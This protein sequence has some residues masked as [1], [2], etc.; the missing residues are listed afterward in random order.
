MRV[1]SALLAV[2]ITAGYQGAIGLDGGPYAQLAVRED[3]AIKK[4]GQGN[5]PTRLVIFFYK[6]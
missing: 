2:L 3:H 5:A 4:Y 1:K 6:R